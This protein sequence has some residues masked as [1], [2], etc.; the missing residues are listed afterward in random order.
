MTL[1]LL[2]LQGFGIRWQRS[3]PINYW[4]IWR[5]IA[6]LKLSTFTTF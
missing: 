5:Q 2:F 6:D 4:A 3:D 1:R